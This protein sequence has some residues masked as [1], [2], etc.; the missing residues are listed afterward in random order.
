VSSYNCLCPDTTIHVSSSKKATG[1]LLSRE[2][3]VGLGGGGEREERRMLRFPTNNRDVPDGNPLTSL[4][5]SVMRCE[6]I[7]VSVVGWNF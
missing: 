4:L 7:T 2:R 5:V 1:R 6:R 3:Q